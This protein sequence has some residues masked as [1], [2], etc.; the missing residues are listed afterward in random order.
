MVPSQPGKT[1]SSQRASLLKRFQNNRDGVTAVEFALVLTPFLLFA[2]GTI[3]IG[4][5]FFTINSLD[6][7]VE[8][9]SRKIRTG[10][11]QR[12]NMTLGDFKSLVCE[13]GGPYIE[14]DCENIYVHVQNATSWAGVAPTN[15]AQNGQMTQQSNTTGAVSESA[16]GGEQVVLVTVCYDWRMPIYLP[17]LNYILMRPTDDIP[18]ASGGS[19][20]QSVATFRSES[21]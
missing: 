19:L 14:Q 1:S 13:E 10:Q 18:L 20:I 3:A 2:I 7:A 16:G 4:L 17:Y 6:H 11:A 15:C 5:Q 12:A 9:A 8:K 21:F